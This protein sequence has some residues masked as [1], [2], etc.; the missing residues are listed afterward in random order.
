MNDHTQSIVT[1]AY[2][3]NMESQ[4]AWVS[5]IIILS[6][7]F[8]KPQISWFGTIS[9]NKEQKI[10]NH[11]SIQQQYSKPLSMGKQSNNFIY[12]FLQTSNEM[13]SNKLLR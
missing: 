8:Y 5:N 4:R 13:T 3:K 12:K 6:F 11:P 9:C 1:Q 7:N 2:N 10:H